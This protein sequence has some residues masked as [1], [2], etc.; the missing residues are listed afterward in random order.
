MKKHIFLQNLMILIAV[1]LLA[2]CFIPSTVTLTSVSAN[3]TAMVEKISIFTLQSSN[4]KTPLPLYILT[5][6]MCIGA[7]AFRITGAEKPLD[8]TLGA[9]V[10]G[11]AIYVLNYLLQNELQISI[12]VL[13]LL[14]IELILSISYKIGRHIGR[15]A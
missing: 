6:L 15:L 12:F 8:W 2:L 5:I 9:S 4:I 1:A 3:G 14:V 11:V 13:V 10:L 7:F